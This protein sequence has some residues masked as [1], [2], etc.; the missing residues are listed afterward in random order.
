M[1]ET[2]VFRERLSYATLLE[3]EDWEEEK[4]GALLTAVSKTVLYALVLL[5]WRDNRKSSE[6]DY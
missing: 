4:I 5:P 3:I 2:Q 1:L 6:T